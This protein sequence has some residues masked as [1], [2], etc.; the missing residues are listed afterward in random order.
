MSLKR[1]LVGVAIGHLASAPFC[2]GQFAN[3]YIHQLSDDHTAIVKSITG[4]HYVQ[5]STSLGATKDIHLMKFDAVGNVVVDKIFFSPSGNEVAL[6]ICRGNNNT[7][8]VCGYEQVGGL[9]LG[10][11]LLV[12]TNFNFLAKVN[13]QVPANDRHTPALNIINSAFYDAPGPPNTYFPPDP[14][15]GYLVTGFEAAGYNAT[16]PKSGYALKLS[17]GLT[18]QWLTKFDS[19]NPPGGPDWDMCSHGTFMWAPPTGYFLGGSG[20]SPAGDQ[21]AMAI[22]LDATGV[23]LW[24]KLYHDA[25][26]P[27][28]SSVAAHAAFDDSPTPM[29]LYQL[30]NHSSHQGGG[31]F[32]FAQGTGV[33][34]LVLS[35]RIITNSLD[36][37]VYEFG[38]TCASNPLL[39]SGYG[40]HQTSGSITGLFPFTFR[41]MKG[42][43]PANSMP[44][45][46]TI[47]QS[48]TKY[49]Y[50]VQSAGYNPTATIFDTYQT[51]GHPRI[52]Y[53][54]LFAQL[55]VNEL[56]M[57]AFEDIGTDHENYLVHPQ[58]NGTD[59]CVYIDPGF[60]AIPINITEWPVNHQPG[61][62]VIT[63]GTYSDSPLVAMVQQCVN[64]PADVGFSVTPG[65]GCNYTFTA[66][67]P[68][69]CPNFTVLDI[70]NTI[71]F[72]SAGP[73][74]NFQFL[75]N[76]TYTI[77]YSDCAVSND[78]LLC[79]DEGCQVIQVTCPPPCTVDADFSFTVNGCCVDFSDLT[80]DGD[81]DG[82]ESWVFGNSGT[83]LAGDVTSYCFPGSGSYTVCHIDCCINTDGTRT[84]H[85][86]CKKVTVNCTPPCCMPT[87]IN[88]AVNGCCVTA[89]PILPGGACTTPMFYYWTMGD[90]N[91]AYQQGL[92][93]CYAK[94]G[95]YTVC[96]TVVCSRTQKVQFCQTIKV[97]CILPPPPPNGGGGTARFGYNTTGTLISLIP[98]PANAT[99]VINSHQWSF[100][101]GQ[102]STAANPSHYYLLSGTYEI[103]HVVE[104][105]D[106]ATGIPFVDEQTSPVTVVLAP[107]CGCEPP[108]TGAFAGGPL[109]CKENNSVLLKLIDFASES[110]IVHQWMVSTCGGP[111]CALSEFVPIPGAIG[112]QVWLEDV[113]ADNHYRCRSTSPLGFVSWSD[114]VDVTY[115]H[116]QIAVEP[117]ATT[118]CPGQPL[119]LEASGADSYAWSTGEAGSS[120]M[121]NTVVQENYIVDGTNTSGCMDTAEAT[122]EMEAGG[123]VTLNA[124]VLLE[125]PLD[126]IA[127]LMNDDL[128]G[129][130][131]LPRNEPY[132]GLGYG[133]G[134]SDGGELTIP[135][136]LGNS[137]PDAILDWL[138]LELRDQADPTQVLAA[139]SA[140]LQRDG[141]V[142]DMDGISPVHFP[143]P[144][145][146]YHVALRHRNHLGAMT[147][148]AIA[149]SPS[150]TSLDFTTNAL[151]TFG[152]DARRTIGS[153]QALWAGDADFN[154]VLKY[155]GSDNDRDPIL[156]AIGGVVPT[157]NSTGYLGTDCD[158][159]GHVKYTGSGNDRDIILQNIG[160]VVPTNS[161]SEQLP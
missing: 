5:A 104:G 40:H 2:Q 43:K 133:W 127:G 27:G 111:G 68:G 42:S 15:G 154:G 39:V 31:F 93:H 63:P 126:P 62:Y 11:V 78:G 26:T 160:G 131:L 98:T 38:A 14:N 130:G 32:T 83:V 66:N 34:D 7:Y 71:V 156:E 115:G 141:D 138:V 76:G 74:V 128:R 67:N 124:K 29:E 20:T 143:L 41:Y 147:A 161:R 90:G 48:M 21:V 159:D 105:I 100:G 88:V 116:F 60:T 36:Y 86:V 73:S 108:P 77:C 149:L 25:A 120:I 136:V 122:V 69:F 28:E 145:D 140:L 117:V 95:I 8:L 24:T 142:V 137:G 123:C 157:A 106:L 84:Y 91:I 87:G 1:I 155:T 135:A 17:D 92:S 103:T 119:V 56:A 37:Y 153:Y 35:S 82:C 54:K 151:S 102:S 152:T 109:L 139:R 121:V 18:F 3:T 99:Y 101:D 89:S 47:D 80:P 49:A 81:P 113:T 96:L 118:V 12:D 61:T 10:F 97:G 58:T 107:A 65:P 57:A 4:T 50:P 114:E 75:I 13:I 129:L 23:P 44:I 51:G 148:N 144:S 6:D 146:L 79:T 59:S 9:D 150:A 30:T 132:T 125:G 134:L 53:P 85:K 46:P 52:Y 22:E 70:A 110:D 33:I 19:P 94:P 72:T 64:C 45:L 158:L 16:D 55:D 112:Q